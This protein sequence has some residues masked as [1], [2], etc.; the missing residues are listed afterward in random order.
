MIS[1]SKILI[2]ILNILSVHASQYESRYFRHGSQLNERDGGTC[3]E[4][5]EINRMD[6]CCMQRDDDCFMIHHDTR[7]YCDVFC[8]REVMNDYSDCCPDAV[9]ACATNT[10]LTKGFRIFCKI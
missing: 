8:N 6:M 1:K 4:F 2:L 7:C 5:L 3:A 9:Q 10:N